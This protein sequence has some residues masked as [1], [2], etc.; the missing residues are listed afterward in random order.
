MH[1]GFLYYYRY[2]SLQFNSYS[3]LLYGF[4]QQF[5]NMTFHIYRFITI[6]NKYYLK[7][8]IQMLMDI[9]F[10]NFIT[11]STKIFRNYTIGMNI[12]K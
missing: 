7:F 8:L 1:I 5:I 2:Y 4:Q 11:Y 10:K 6:N 3:V 12:H 9:I